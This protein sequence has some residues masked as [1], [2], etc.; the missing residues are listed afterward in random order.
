MKKIRLLYNCVSCS[1]FNECRMKVEIKCGS[2]FA[3]S[4]NFSGYN[5]EDDFWEQ[6]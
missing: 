6:I 3:S 4:I 5:T 1:S 2:D